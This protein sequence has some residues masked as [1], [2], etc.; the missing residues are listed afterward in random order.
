MNQ[1]G[2]EVNFDGIVG[3]THNYS[4]LSYGNVASMQ[5]GKQTSNPRAAALQGLEKMKLACGSRCQTSGTSSPRKTPFTLIESF[6]LHRSRQKYP[7][8]SV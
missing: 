3:P 5:H 8:K 4:A 6:R 1:N 2:F 7:R